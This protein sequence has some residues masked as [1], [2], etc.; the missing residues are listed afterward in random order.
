[1]IVR[2]HRELIRRYEELKPGDI[3]IGLVGDKVLRQSLLIDCLQ[4]G[5]R[6][7][8]S[9]LSQTLHHFKTA[10]ARILGR[11]ML[12]LT[13]V[14]SRRSD[15]LA[16]AG[17]YAK[18]GIG[19]V[20]TK[21]DHMHC[22]HGVRKWES[23]E[24]L[25]NLAGFSPGAFPFVMQ[26]F[27]ASFTDI[28]V[29]VADDYQEAYE[30]SNP[31]SFRKNLSAGGKSRPHELTPEQTSFCREV[32]TR[33]GF[34]YAHIDLHVTEEGR[35]YLSEIT[36]NGGLKGAKISRDELDRR[37]QMILESQAAKD[38]ADAGG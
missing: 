10:Q 15:L 1:M 14:I 11:W 8:P 29:V 28:R 35:I 37:K 36:L 16:A 20:V 27:L 21:Q 2:G 33:G 31:G 22:G 17:L 34:A 19:P 30:R 5:I 12:P 26:P 24:I 25:Y 6:C 7:Y 38:G 13:R 9:A 4:R 3:F 18:A 23:V 32:M